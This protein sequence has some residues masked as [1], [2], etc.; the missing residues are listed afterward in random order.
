MPVMSI[1]MRE[2]GVPLAQTLY[3]AGMRVFEITL[4]SACA[5]Q[6]ISDIRQA[7]P[8]AIVGAGTVIEA[9]QVD[10]VKS[11]GGQFIVTPGLSELLLDA[12]V[13]SQLPVIP[14]ITSPSELIQGYQRGLRCF[15]FY[16]AELS[17]GRTM[18]K[19]FHGPFSDVM[20]CPTGGLNLN[21]FIDYLALDNVPIVGGTWLT[22]LEYV[23]QKDWATISKLV[24]QTHSSLQMHR[25]KGES[26]EQKD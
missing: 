5:L 10:Q 24:Q 17:G 12:L 20:F 19:A 6:V 15:K 18:L 23:E 22:P 7:L 21:N 4:R 14:G 3:D 16:P 26:H 2:L 1:P 11:A 8:D 9:A 13:D 25:T